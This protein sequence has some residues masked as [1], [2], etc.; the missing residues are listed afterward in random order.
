MP[1]YLTATRP[2][3]NN[4]VYEIDAAV[5]E[6]DQKEMGVRT[7]PDLVVR[8]RR[9]D[10]CARRGDGQPGPRHHGRVQRLSV[11]CT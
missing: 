2:D 11:P 6:L 10:R 4:K 8:P 9:P 3:T 5:V 7:G 1:R